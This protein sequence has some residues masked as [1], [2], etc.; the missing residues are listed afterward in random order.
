M[1]AV[2]TV[3]SPNGIKLNGLFESLDLE[4]IVQS[5]LESE[6]ILRNKVVFKDDVNV[7]GEIFSGKLISGFNL[8]GLCSYVFG[9][10]SKPLRNLFVEGTINLPCIL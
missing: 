6:Q 2:K 10:A 9:S 7:N 4:D 1:F 5:N 8:N 3:T